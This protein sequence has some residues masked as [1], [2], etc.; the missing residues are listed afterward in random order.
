MTITT[1]TD[2]PA[3]LLPFKGQTLRYGRDVPRMLAENDY[4]A[5]W[6]CANPTRPWHPMGLF[7]CAWRQDETMAG[8]EVQPC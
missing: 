8:D 1:H 6:M 5:A 2:V 4:V 7:G 3:L